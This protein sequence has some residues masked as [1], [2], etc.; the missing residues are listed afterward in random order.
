[1]KTE[2]LLQFLLYLSYS[3]DFV[4][5]LL[6]YKLKNG[7]TSYYFCG[8]QN[9]AFSWDKNVI[10]N[11]FTVTFDKAYV[12]LLKNTTDPSLWISAINQIQEVW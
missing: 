2:I 6:L 3:V 10:T 5:F 7:F 9:I 11:A 12:L 8:N 1:M 4:P